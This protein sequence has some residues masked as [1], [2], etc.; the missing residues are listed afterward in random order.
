[1]NMILNERA[2]NMRLRLG[3][4]K[5]FWSD[6]ITGVSYVINRGHLTS[7]DYRIPYEV[8]SDKEINIS[9]L[10]VLGCVQ[11]IHIGFTAKNKLDAKLERCFFIGY[12][13]SEFGYHFWDDQTHKIIKRNDVVYEN[14]LYKDKL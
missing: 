14:V 6:A 2:K 3:L 5:M 8:W 7:M 4:S 13:D 1:M 10:K 11:Y 9:H 12:G